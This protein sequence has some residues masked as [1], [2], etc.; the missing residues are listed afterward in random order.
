[1]KTVTING[2]PYSIDG[3][4]AYMYNSSVRLGMLV[5]NAVVLD[6]DWEKNASRYINEYRE[7]LNSK[8]KSAMEKAV[9]LQRAS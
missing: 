7:Y 5:E 2:I 3:T 1:M 8:T 6:K 4:I 9:T